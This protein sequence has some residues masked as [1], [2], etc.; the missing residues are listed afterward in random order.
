MASFICRLVFNYLFISAQLFFQIDYSDMQTI[1]S[2][3][4]RSTFRMDH[5]GI[6]LMYE[7]SVSFTRITCLPRHLG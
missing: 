4:Q 1:H 3:N 5:H 6:N 2:N 7:D